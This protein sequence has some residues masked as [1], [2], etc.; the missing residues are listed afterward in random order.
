MTNHNKDILTNLSKILTNSMLT[1]A[2]NDHLTPDNKAHSF[3]SGSIL[4]K[5]EGYYF[6]HLNFEN[7]TII[8]GLGTSGKL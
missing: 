5:G 7:Y 2:E 6:W 1:V 4:Y 8:Q 3:L